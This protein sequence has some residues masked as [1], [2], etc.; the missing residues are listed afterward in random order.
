MW[1]VVQAIDAATK[2][3]AAKACAEA[4]AVFLLT[5]FLAM[6]SFFALLQQLIAKHKKHSHFVNARSTIIFFGNQKKII[7]RSKIEEKKN[8]AKHTHKKKTKQSN[9]N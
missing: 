8:E 6:A 1:T 3:R 5:T 7:E 4:F 9:A 2:V